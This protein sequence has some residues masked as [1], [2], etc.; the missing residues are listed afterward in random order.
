MSRWIKFLIA[1]AIGLALGLLYGWLVSPVEYIDTSPDTLRADYQLDYVLMVAETYQAEQNLDLAARR[2]A[3]LGSDLP[4]DIVAVALETA[5]Q[6]GIP[7]NDRILIQDLGAALL[8]WQ[9]NS[10]GSLP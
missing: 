8:D 10:G 3:M 6:F 2:L 5:L 4:A 9:P 7:E 1:I